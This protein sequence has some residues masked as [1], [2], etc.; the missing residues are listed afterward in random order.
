MGLPRGRLLVNRDLQSIAASCATEN[1]DGYNAE[2]IPNGVIQ[3]AQQFIDLIPK[4][5]KNY[6]LAPEPCGGVEITWYLPQ[7]QLLSVSIYHK[8]SI[9]FAYITTNL[10]MYGVAEFDKKIPFIIITLLKTANL[11]FANCN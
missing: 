10:H 1:W 6:T 9:G 2:P 7:G 3:K 4:E 8:F 11:R 5:F